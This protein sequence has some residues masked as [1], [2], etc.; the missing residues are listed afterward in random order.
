M[1][2]GL[3]IAETEEGHK[4]KEIMDQ[5][6]CLGL[7]ERDLV[8]S[9]NGQNV[10]ELSHE[11][12]VELLKNCPKNSYATFVV[13]RRLDRNDGVSLFITCPSLSL[14][15]ILIFICESCSLVGD[16]RLRD[17]FKQCFL[18]MSMMMKTRILLS[19]K[20]YCF[21]ENRRDLG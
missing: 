1:G 20:K 6:R 14:L 3:R 13:E 16:R 8:I 5:E 7:R 15:L 21:T 10:K 18:R 19:P 11:Q 2:F 9:I 12:V 4:I 17:L